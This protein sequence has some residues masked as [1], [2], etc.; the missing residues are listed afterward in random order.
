MPGCPSTSP[1]APT[2]RCS[3][4]RWPTSWPS[5]SVTWGSMWSAAAAARTPAHIAALVAR[6]GG[7][8]P[9][10]RLVQERPRLA[11][12]HPRHRPATRSRRRCSSVSASTPRDRGRSRS[13][14]SPTTTTASSAWAASRWRAAPTRWMCCVALTERGDEGRADG[15][16]SS[17]LSRGV[18]APLMID[19]TE[20]AVIRRAL[21]AYPGRG[22]V[23]SIN[24]E[25]GRAAHRRRAAPGARPRRRRRRADDR[26]AGDG[27]EPRAQARG[28]PPHPRHRLQ[29]YGLRATPS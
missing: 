3:R 23:N 25:N 4:T 16:R 13:C 28:G 6:V 12:Q 20:R 19:S 27:P 26:R 10:P 21:E 24:M 2:T 7:A 1:V 29:E 14:C 5:L 11:S 9:V 15:D 18:E 8:T 17:R 22:I